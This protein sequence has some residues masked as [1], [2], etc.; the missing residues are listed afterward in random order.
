LRPYREAGFIAGGGG[1]VFKAEVRGLMLYVKYVDWRKKV[2]FCIY[3][4]HYFT[5]LLGADMMI[6]PKNYPQKLQMLKSQPKNKV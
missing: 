5:A 3:F 2:P 6:S 1:G 4:V